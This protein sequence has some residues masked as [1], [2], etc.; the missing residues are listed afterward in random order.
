MARI[1]IVGWEQEANVLLAE[2]WRVLRLPA[3]LLPPPEAARILRGGDVAIG[4]LDVVKSLDGVEPGLDV[5]GLVEQA[6]ARVLNRAGALLSAHDK[7]LTARRLELAG[8]PHPAS[9]FVP[10]G[11]TSASI[12]APLVLKPRFGSWGRD[13]VRCESEAEVSSVLRLLQTRTW[14]RNQGAV[15]QALVPPQGYDL[16]LLVADAQV[17]GAARRVAS[18]GEW[19]TNISLGGSREPAEPTAEAIRLALAAAAAIGADF[20]GVDL[21]PTEHGH[22]VLELNGAVE[23]DEGYGLHGRDVYAD[24]ARALKLTQSK[25]AA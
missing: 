2:A 18:P 5:L 21:L 6:G 4:R 14:F 25:L 13:V 16:R 22:L 1:G 12:P 20:V 24:A 11:A 17:V 23:F 7:L 19:R 3:A 10:P 15:A 9:V 8:V